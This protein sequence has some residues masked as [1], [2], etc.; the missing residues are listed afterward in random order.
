M[1]NQRPR[2]RKTVVFTCL[3]C[4]LLYICVAFLKLKELCDSVRHTQVERICLG[5]QSPVMV[6]FTF[7]SKYSSAEEIQITYN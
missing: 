2:L 6:T 5:S 7:T 4:G 1:E 3:N